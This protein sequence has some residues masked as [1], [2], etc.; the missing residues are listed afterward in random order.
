MEWPPPPLA[1]E[2]CL[3]S[4][5]TLYHTGCKAFIEV[6]THVT[7]TQL[8]YDSPSK[9]DLCG[10]GCGPSCRGRDVEALSTYSHTGVP[11][12]PRWAACTQVSCSGVRSTLAYSRSAG[13]LYE[14]AALGTCRMSSCIVRA[15]STRKG[16]R[17]TELWD[18]MWCQ[19]RMHHTNA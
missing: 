5:P 18:T 6:D 1:M 11:S 13:S 14:F 15:R 4:L 10:E 2:A 12:A 9:Q 8:R 19:M 7:A 3:H 17:L 16:V